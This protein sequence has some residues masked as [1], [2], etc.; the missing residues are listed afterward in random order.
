[1]DMAEGS[2]RTFTKWK[3][4]GENAVQ[5]FWLTTAGVL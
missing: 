2:I 1:M 4:T 5:I 3:N